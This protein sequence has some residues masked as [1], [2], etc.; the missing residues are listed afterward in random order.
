MF[1]VSL[2]AASTRHPDH[3][4]RT[5]C[6]TGACQ[7]PTS[8]KAQLCG[9]YGDTCTDVDTF[10]QV[11]E[12]IVN[13]SEGD[14]RKVWECGVL[15]LGPEFT[16]SFLLSS[17]AITYLQSSAR[18]KGTEEITEEDVHEIAG[19]YT[20]LSPLLNHFCTW[21]AMPASLHPSQ[22]VPDTVLDS[23]IKAC[24]SDSYER[25]QSCIKV[26]M[27]LCCCSNSNGK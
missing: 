13:A 10:P 23:L 15:V 8:G 18:L 12:R 5:H 14:L 1:Q 3:S 2:Q 4:A 27:N 22:I 20:H 9:C 24:Y 7:L 16:P 19:V 26:S 21:C 17:Q 6:T 11:L 25:L